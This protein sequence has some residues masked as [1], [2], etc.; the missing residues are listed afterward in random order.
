[1][2]FGTFDLL[3]EGHKF[4]INQAKEQGDHLTI[5]V[6]R[7]RTVSRLKKQTSHESEQ[8]RQKSVEALNI[9]DQVILGS[10]TDHFTSIREHT[11]DLIVLGYDQKHFATTLKEDL[12][13]QGLEHIQ[14]IRA[15]AYKPEQYKTS[16]I[17]KQSNV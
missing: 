8:Q 10:T 1:M 14:I 11:P 12:K 16:I 6:A 5:V 13:Q 9:A 7:D 4:F 2:I 15:A 17:R 3:H